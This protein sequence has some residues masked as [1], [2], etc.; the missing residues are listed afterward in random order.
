MIFVGDIH[1]DWEK[2]TRILDRHPTEEIFQI[3][4]LGLGFP[5]AVNLRTGK[6]FRTDPKEFPERFRFI[7]GNHDNP[8]VCRSY[9][10][11]AGDF[12]YDEATK[13]FWMGGAW[14]IDHNLRTMG[15]DW[16]HDEELSA[17]QCAAAADLYLSVRP[18][19]VVTHTCPSTLIPQMGFKD[20][21]PVSSTERTLD[22]M[23]AEHKPKRWFFGHWHIMWEEE[24]LGTKFT[25]LNTNGTKKVAMAG[26]EPARV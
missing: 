25:C 23:W 3:G 26:V 20:G 8:E 13:M 14:S 15:V 2:L 9:P 4:D 5:I 10:N 1:G 12:G 7:R 6:P 22:L 18:D 19:V 17:A 16:W 24:I 11:Y 21:G